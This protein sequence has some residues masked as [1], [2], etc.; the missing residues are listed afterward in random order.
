MFSLFTAQLIINFDQTGLNITPTSDWT[1][2]QCGASDVEILCKEDKRQI[3]CVLACTLTG[4]L[5][6]PQLVYGGKT[7]RCHPSYTFP[8]DWDITHS[9]NHWSNSA[10]M[11]RYVNSILAPYCNHLRGSDGI[12]DDQWALC[13]LDV[14]KAHQKDTVLKAFAQHRIKVVFVPPNC[15][16]VLQPLDIS[17][18]GTFKAHMKDA[19]Q[20]WYASHVAASVQDEE[21]ALVNVDTRLTTLKP[22]HAAWIVRAWEALSTNTSVLRNGWVKAG[23]NDLIE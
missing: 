2:E 12:P 23:I 8:S 16:G 9:E 1:M 6:P 7:A 5:L 19:F 10:T 20:E 14:F 4:A 3:T 21:E 13:I 18:N 15:M 17:G 11:E 22:L